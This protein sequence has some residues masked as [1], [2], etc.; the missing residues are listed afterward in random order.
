[1]KIY[2]LLP[3][4]LLL[5]TAFVGSCSTESDD[6]SEKNKMVGLSFYHTDTN[7]EDFSYTFGCEDYYSLQDASK[8]IGGRFYEDSFEAKDTLITY[9]QDETR[10]LTLSFVSSTKATLNESKTIVA[11]QTILTKCHAHYKFLANLQSNS[12]VYSL[13][14]TEDTFDFQNK[15]TGSHITL[16]LN[17]NREID[18]IFYL[19]KHGD[20]TTNTFND[21]NNINFTY[22]INAEDGRV[23]FSDIIGHSAYG[24][25]SGA[26]GFTLYYN[27]V[28]YQ[29][30]KT[31]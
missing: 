2:R 14:V 26:N 16:Q 13:I 25:I 9:H 17:G 19:D 15:R 1:M 24:Y 23:T 12:D 5:L 29:M 27:N 28:T 4:S 11:K 20:S 31:K 10:K 3:A 6:E 30:S 22:Q 8:Y 21:D 18:F 7:S